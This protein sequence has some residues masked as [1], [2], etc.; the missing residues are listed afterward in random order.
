MTRPT[1]WRCLCW[2]LTIPTVP[3]TIAY[4][5]EGKRVWCDAIPALPERGTMED[6]GAVAFLKTLV[7]YQHPDH[8]TDAWPPED[9]A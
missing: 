8:D 7:N 9:R 3:P 5:V 6:A 4:G 2:R 1:G